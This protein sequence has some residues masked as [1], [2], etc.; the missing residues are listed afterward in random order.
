MNA[1]FNPADLITAAVAEATA[2]PA[3]WGEPDMSV[4]QQNRRPAPAFPLD[5]LGPEW[6]SWV[7]AAAA[8][9]SAPVDYVVMPLLASASALI[10]N[11]RWP[12]AWPG[13]V[14]PPHLWCGVVG[15]SGDGKSP[16]GDTLFRDVLPDIEANMMQGFPER[17]KAWRTAA[18]SHKARQEVWEDGV[19]T[20]NK[21]GNPPPLPPD[22]PPP[23]PQAPRLRQT[24]VTIEKMASLLANAAPK[25]VLVEWDE[26]VG[27]FKGMTNYNDAGRQ[28]WLQAYGGR[29]YRV[30]R[31]ATP[32]PIIIPRLVV[33]ATG[34]VQPARMAEMFK[35]ADDGL[36][37]RFLWT[38]PEPIPFKR[39]SRTP[40]VT[41]AINALDRLRA[42]EMLPPADG[43]PA[44]PIYVPLSDKAADMMVAL[45]Q[46]MQQT[47]QGAGGLMKSAYGKAVARQS[48]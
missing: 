33:A 41:W 10:G 18:A 12:Q 32:E 24:D 23:E 37:A 5:E 11:A 42:L 30:E 27:W 19:K 35:D 3:P 29:T 46:T 16:G 22:D 2:P 39:P 38:W 7:S 36:M 47:K 34:G 26:L 20:A 9:A 15:D 48:G 43:K 21:T 31:K 8:S 13:W 44:G 28:F 1:P 4:L 45:I 14:E 17:L 25:G 6:S 40:D